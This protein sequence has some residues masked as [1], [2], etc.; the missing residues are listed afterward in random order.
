METITT[1]REFIRNFARLK[2]VAANG[3]EIIVRDRKGK[4]FVFHAKGAGPSL[5]SQLAD[6]QGALHT[7][8]P[9]K[10]LRGFG[11]NRP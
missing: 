1:S 8:T 4:S 6:L 7:G 11:R 10:N 2:K 5:A 3:T 9:V